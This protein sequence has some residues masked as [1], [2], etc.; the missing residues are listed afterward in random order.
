M[1]PS[2]KAPL[3]V[4]CED[5]RGRMVKHQCCPGCGYFCTA[6]SA[7]SP[8]ASGLG[9]HP[10]AP[11][12]GAA[13]AAPQLPSLGSSEVCACAHTLLHTRAH[14]ARPLPPARGLGLQGQRG[15]G[16]RLWAPC[17]CTARPGKGPLC[18]CCCPRL[19][20]LLGRLPQSLLP[21]AP[22]PSSASC[23]AAVDATLYPPVCNARF[24]SGGE[25]EAASVCSSV[26]SSPFVPPRGLAGGRCV[27]GAEGPLQMS[28]L[29]PSSWRSADCA[30][31]SVP[32][33]PS[34]AVGGLAQVQMAEHGRGLGRG[35]GPGE[36]HSP[37]G[38]QGPPG[39][40]PSGSV[41][42]FAFLHSSPSKALPS[43]SRP[44]QLHGVP[45]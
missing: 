41:T 10:S 34:W 11:S 21:Q 3:L 27:P 33:G 23:G 42:G 15:L 25:R 4:L 8:A 18:C 38:F 44:G 43:L 5:H 31:W 1:R 37:A 26:S 9:R 45:A 13:G 6:V 35:V 29:A 16:G 12:A 36:G 39:W 24:A 7:R 19:L 22:V 17:E 30:F 14:T 40:P 20:L 2:S 28:V 32:H